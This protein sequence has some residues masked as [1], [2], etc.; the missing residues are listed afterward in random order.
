MNSTRIRY[1]KNA[2]G[3]LVSVKAFTHATNGTKFKIYINETDQ[4]YKVVEDLS[5]HMVTEGR[6]TNLHQVKAK[7]KQKLTELGIVFEAEQRDVAK[8]EAVA[9]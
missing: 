2:E 7:A 1:R 8:E 9:S 5:G 3:I 6:A 4:S